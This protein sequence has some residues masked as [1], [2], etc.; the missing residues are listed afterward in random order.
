MAELGL[1]CFALAFSSCSKWRRLFTAAHRLLIVVASLVSKHG[2]QGGWAAGAAAHRLRCSESCGIFPDQGLNAGPQNWQAILS[3]WATR[4][5][6]RLLTFKIER[7]DDWTLHFWILYI[8]KTWSVFPLHSRNV[9]F[10]IP[11][12]KIYSESLLSTHK[13][14]KITWSLICFP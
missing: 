10:K 5:I 8:F 12:S 3:H 1:C 14:F 4:D 7:N 6:Q 13:H 2:L 11:F 9:F